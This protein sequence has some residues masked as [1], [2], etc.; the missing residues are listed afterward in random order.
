MHVGIILSR[1]KDIFFTPPEV[2]AA[3]LGSSFFLGPQQ[4]F[5]PSPTLV[6]RRRTELTRHTQSAAVARTFRL[7]FRKLLR[8]VN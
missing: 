1:R 2:V 3:K 4:W 6:M 5:F 8:F 7:V